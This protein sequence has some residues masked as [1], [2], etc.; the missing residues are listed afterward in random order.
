MHQQL[1]NLQAGI[2]ATKQE[3][4]LTI[5]HF[6]RDAHK[7]YTS[8]LEEFENRTTSFKLDY[9]AL[10][11]VEEA[12]TQEVIDL[13]RQLEEVLAEKSSG[14]KEEFKGELKEELEDLDFKDRK[15][16]LETDE[17]D[18]SDQNENA[19]GEQSGKK[20]KVEVED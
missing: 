18:V 1:Q 7:R 12:A 13:R 14:V 17:I 15:R 6:T 8:L 20:H 2:A 9:A 10:K 3:R 16:L 19:D 11:K 5:L 4:D